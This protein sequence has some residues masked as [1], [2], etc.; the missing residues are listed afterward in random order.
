[1]PLQHSKLLAHTS[2]F[3]EQNDP[4]LEQSPLRQTLEQH[5]E[6]F[7]H[8]LPVVR[9][10]GLSGV[11]VP[12]APHVPLQHCADVVQAWLSNVHCIVPQ[13]PPL[14]TKVQQF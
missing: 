2:V 8:P 11:H 5:S 13:T 12:P 7:M 4:P 9:Q 1:M 3:C 14:H 10:P 6:W